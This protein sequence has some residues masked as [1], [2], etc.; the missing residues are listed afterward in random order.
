MKWTDQDHPITKGLPPTFI[1]DDEVYHKIDLKSNVH[2]LATA[3]D[4]PI[5]GR[6]STSKDEPMVWTAPAARL[7]RAQG[8]RGLH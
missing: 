4:D 6:A 5:G 2:V 8:D 1:A 7:G 3:F